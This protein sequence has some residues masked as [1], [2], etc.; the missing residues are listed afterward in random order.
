M[1]S[2]NLKAMYSTV[3]KD[4]FPTHM[5]IS[6]HNGNDER[7]T[8]FY[9]KVEWDIAGERMGLRYG[10]NPDQPAGFYK[11]V[12]GNL[13]LGEVSMIHPGKYLVSDIELVQSGK[14]P[15]KTNITDADN[16][17]NILRYFSDK[18]ATVIVKHNN[19]CGV[20]IGSSLADSYIKA[21]MADRVAAFGGAI[22]V[23][24]PMDLQTAEL[25]CESYCEVVVA[26]DF[27]DGVMALFAGKK[28][29]RVMKIG[30]IAA[31]SEY[32]GEKFL[33]FKSVF[34]GGLI[35]QWSFTPKLSRDDLLPAVCTY[36]DVDYKVNREPTEAEYE[37]MMFGWLVES[38]IT[39]NSV[40]Y[41][42]DGVTIGIGTGE[43]DR[44]G[45][46]EIARDK[47]YKKLSDRLAWERYATP[48]NLLKSAEKR[49]EIEKEVEESKGG[50]K[51]SVMISD[52][53]FPFRDGIEV[54]LNEG[55]K[56]VIQPGGSMRDFE[57]IEA[58]NEYDAAMVFT[59]QR[60]FKH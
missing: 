20:A 30:N 3:N 32:I 27:E 52:A 15:G 16:A 29:L 14:H 18:P 41:V 34:D 21:L 19:P 43:Q 37:D 35:A 57:S 4:S 33:D 48:W 60:S 25:I 28:N 10:E 51:G 31:L 13:S 7:Q 1:S 26:P 49:A 17:L 44:V 40:I 55:I 23:N 11:L 45:V 6:F 2:K 38:G 39:S 42:K 58:C 22:A 56:A 8:L 54:G 5:D 50:L 47:A 9:E 24:R 46:A 36:K 12:N 59:G 53:F